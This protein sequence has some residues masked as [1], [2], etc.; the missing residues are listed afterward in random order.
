MTI[1]KRI[2]EERKRL[3]FTQ[4]QFAKLTGVSFSSQRRYED[5]RSAPDTD[6]LDALDR[7]GVDYF[8]VLTG[9][10]RGF[11]EEEA[12]L[13]V[14]GLD[15]G[16]SKE[17]ATRPDIA[18]LITG[19][20]SLGVGFDCDFFLEVLGITKEDWKEIAR[21]NLRRWVSDTSGKAIPAIISAPWTTWGPDLARASHVVAGMLEVAA[22]LDS[23]LLAEVLVGFDSEL[24]AQG[25]ATMDSAKKAQAVAMLYRAFKASGKVD[26]AMIEE[27]VKLAAS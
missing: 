9:L 6:Y 23:A 14:N 25:Q 8:Y 19:D 15:R 5:G 24:A 21:R 10:A 1:G 3:G 13:Y 4:A 12:K 26:P 17:E 27:A 16:F 7:I 2:A 18:H 20:T 22:A 11:S